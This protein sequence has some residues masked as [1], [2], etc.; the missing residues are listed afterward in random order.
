MV[1]V[2][3]AS[4]QRLKAG[5]EA[6]LA[7]YAGRL[8]KNLVGKGPDRITVRV[9]EDLIIIRY[10]GILCHGERLLATTNVELVKAY[11]RGLTASIWPQVKQDLLKLTGVEPLW[12]AADVDP[13]LDERIEV[14]AMM[15]DMEGGVR[16]KKEVRKRKDL[17]QGIDWKA[18]ARLK[19]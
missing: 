1:D 4:D 10:W 6:E 15:L 12:L 18:G 7:R 8:W 14:L 3:E 9:V 19:P 2:S 11:Y 5:L 17:D 16:G 13:Q